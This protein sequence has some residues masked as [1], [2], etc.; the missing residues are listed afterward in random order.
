MLNRSL[1]SSKRMDWATP[2]DLFQKLDSEFNFTLDVCATKDNAKCTRYITPKQNALAVSWG[3]NTC[4]MN[5]P[6]GREI[7]KWMEKAHQESQLGAMV[8][9]LVPARTDTG[10]WHRHSMCG[11]IRFLKGR[12]KFVGAKHCAPFPSAIIIFRPAGGQMQP[13]ACSKKTRRG[14]R[15]LP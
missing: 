9:C 13:R 10:W 6:Y 8:V 5:P 11:E 1:L 7:G 4:F 3:T 14:W 2:Q 12:I 15:D